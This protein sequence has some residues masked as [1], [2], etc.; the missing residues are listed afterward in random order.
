MKRAHNI[1]LIRP[2]LVVVLSILGDRSLYKSVG[3][4]LPSNQA[5]AL[6]TGQPGS[7]ARFS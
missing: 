5:Q 7:R 6:S 2:S 1:A 3:Q 4:A